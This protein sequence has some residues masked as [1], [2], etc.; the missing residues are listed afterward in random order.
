MAGGKGNGKNMKFMCDKYATFV[1]NW[2][3]AIHLNVV[4]TIVYD[5]LTFTFTEI[6]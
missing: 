6:P 1:P 4:S 3:H 5:S 2:E